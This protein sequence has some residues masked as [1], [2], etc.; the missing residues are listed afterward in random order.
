MY[1]LNISSEEKRTLVSVLE[2]EIAELR[3]QIVHTDRYAFKQGLKNRRELL[4]GLLEQ[5]RRQEVAQ[6]S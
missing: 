3:S 1:A 6:V 5:L 4:L 2:S